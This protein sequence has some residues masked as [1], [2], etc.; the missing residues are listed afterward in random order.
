MFRVVPTGAA[1]ET[2]PVLGTPCKNVSCW[3]E[4]CLRAPSIILY[5]AK[6]FRK[7]EGRYTSTFTDL[8]NFCCIFLE[9]NLRGSTR[10]I[11]LFWFYCA[12]R[13]GFSIISVMPSAGFGLLQLTIMLQQVQA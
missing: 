4:Y 11:L 2:T 1:G 3:E 10:I 7:C 8:R 13:L 6:S 12:G 9:S 5:T